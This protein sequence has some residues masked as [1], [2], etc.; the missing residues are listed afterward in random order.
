MRNLDLDDIVNIGHKHV[1][2]YGGKNPAPGVGEGLNKPAF[3]TYFNFPIPENSTDAHFKTKLKKWAQR[4]SAELCS[5]E[6]SKKHLTI[7]VQKFH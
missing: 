3:I 6:E 5:Y 1:N 7:K 2:M 4:N